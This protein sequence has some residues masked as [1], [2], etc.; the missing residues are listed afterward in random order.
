MDSL[1][2]SRATY[3]A[4][5]KR[6]LA[7]DPDLDEQTLVDTLEGMTDLHEVIAAIVRA[8]VTDEALSNGLRDR[9]SE[10]QERLER[11]EDRATRRRR[12]A[13]EAM[14]EASIK[15]IT[16]PDFTLFLRNGTPALVVT[17]EATIP[18]PY[19]VP[20]PPRLDRQAL[21]AD[22]KRGVNIAGAT[23]GNPTPVLSVRTK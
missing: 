2:F 13:C 4:L 23:L 21:Y 14:A 12:I 5:R 6:L 10:M 16:A 11:F 22:L 20:R 7:D 17:D 19:W 9:I 15:K 1:A 3:K 8:A 18:E